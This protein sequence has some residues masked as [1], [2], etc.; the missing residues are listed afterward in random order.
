[1]PGGLVVLTGKGA[2]QVNGGSS[3][4]ITPSNQTAVPQAYNGSSGTVPPI[5]IN[6]DILY[7]QAKGSIVRDLAYNFFTNIYT[8]TDLTV[9]SD[10]LFT[11]YQIVQWAWSEEPYKLIWVVRNDGTLLCL[12][13]LKEQEVYS[14]TRHDT[15][16]L[17]VSVCSVTEPPVDAVYVITKRYVQGAWRYYSERM[18][19]RIWNNVEDCFCVDSGLSYPKTYPASTLTV[20]SATGTAVNFSTS[21]ASFNSGMVGNIIRAG[22][23][24]AVITTYNSP[25]SV[26]CDILQ[27]ITDTIPNNPNNMPVPFVGGSW[28]IAVPISTVSGLNHLEG[29]EVAILA[30]GSVVPNQTVTNNSVTLPVAASNIV[31][32][33]PYT[34]QMQTMYLDVPSQVTVQNRRKLISSVGIRCVET[35]GIQL[36]ADQPDASTQP[37]YATI[38]WTQMNEVK[39][40]TMSIDAGT[41]VPLFTGDYFKNIASGWDVKGQVAVQQIYPLPANI[42]S[43]ISYTTIGDDK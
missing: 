2:W 30:D 28:S 5:T 9:L 23:G 12:T 20:N 27:D 42:L 43:V 21:S 31:V 35:R 11:D 40:R 39:E 29:L 41:A 14:W 18:D 36:G 25:T 19:N 32:G 38:P 22:G 3:A 37:N 15:N 6:Y 4:A 16:G 24:M 34:C 7:V 13:Y 8:G 1:M 10:H 33:L 26:T 17:F